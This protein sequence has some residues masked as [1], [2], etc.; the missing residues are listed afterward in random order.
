M[1]S[2]GQRQKIHPT[3]VQAHAIFRFLR[4]AFCD[5][6]NRFN[7]AKTPVPLRDW[8][9]KSDVL[10]RLFAW[11][12]F[13]T[14]CRNRTYNCPLGGGCY[15]H[16]TKEAFKYFNSISQSVEEFKRC[17]DFWRNCIN[18]TVVFVTVPEYAMFMV[19]I[20]HEKQIKKS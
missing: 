2:K 10:P 15:I 13:G 4:T 8:R 6:G 20:L 16:L 18:F 19:C 12:N 1:D 17:A 11:Q 14:P 7:T 5:K 3:V 9:E